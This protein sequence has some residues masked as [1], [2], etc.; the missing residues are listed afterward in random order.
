MRSG[1]I[2]RLLPLVGIVAC[3]LVGA[4]LSWVVMRTHHEQASTEPPPQ[5][6][7][8]QTEEHHAPTPTPLPAPAPAPPP[9]PAHSP[10]VPDPLVGI[11]ERIDLGDFRRA[12]R[13]WRE[14][15]ESGKL[16]DDPLNRARW[17]IICEGLGEF[18]EARGEYEKLL[19]ALPWTGR[20]GEVRC[21]FGLKRWS[22]AAAKLAALDEHI[23]SL[24]S[25]E[26]EF[27]AEAAYLRAY[28][29]LQRTGPT[30]PDL[31]SPQW[32]D[33]PRWPFA[34]GRYLQLAQ[35]EWQ[36]PPSKPRILV[37]WVHWRKPPDEEAIPRDPV[38]LR[39]V[40]GE[41][42][43]SNP[44]HPWAPQMRLEWARRE[45][46][47]EPHRAVRIFQE[48]LTND[49]PAD[50]AVVARCELGW[51]QFREGDKLSARATLMEAI[52]SRPEGPLAPWAWWHVARTHADY[53]DFAPAIRAY[54]LSLARGDGTIRVAAAIG[55]ATLHLLDDQ[56]SDA[57]ELLEKVKGDRLRTGPLWRE[58]AL[59]DA[60]AR[61]RLAGG[62]NSKLRSVREELLLA[63]SDWPE[64]SASGPTGTLLRVQVH[65][66]LGLTP[67]A[68]AELERAVSRAGGRLAAKLTWALALAHL[69]EGSEE[70][71][72]ECL[73]NLVVADDNELSALAHLTL[74]RLELQSRRP[75]ACVQRC[76]Q[77]PAVSAASA[78]ERLRLMGRAFEML[79]DYERAAACFAGQEPSFRTSHLSR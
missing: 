77:M 79:G 45:A 11:D 39:E 1:K 67:L 51:A 60:W 15:A 62:S 74:A 29:E 25:R 49:L 2:I 70:S 64:I 78:E 8:A 68:A 37:H 44:E 55:L 53:A 10:K 54:R 9:A 5:A 38:H 35:R 41:A 18:A 24:T 72:R 13:E 6:E 48:F 50:V 58:A 36:Q 57:R 75:K 12:K 56:P 20:L 19:P 32:Y 61:W 52:D 47:A 33:K 65:R 23:G 71:A 40:L 28:L 3:A 16:A 63:L 17:A 21:L 59:I 30:A 66:D 34:G 26:A 43:R 22:D 4:S 7:L 42:L 27:A 69:H 31:W 46:E 14:A 73:G 76:L